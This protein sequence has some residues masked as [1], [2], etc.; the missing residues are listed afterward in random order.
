[1]NTKIKICDVITGAGKTQSAIKY[2]NESSSR[3][4]FITPYLD[5][6]TRIEKECPGK[7]FQQPN[8]F[9]SKLVN[10]KRL[11]TSSTHAKGG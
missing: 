11:S 6:C 1:V 4:I 2:M 5:E 8:E 10:L 3:F 7:N 9:P